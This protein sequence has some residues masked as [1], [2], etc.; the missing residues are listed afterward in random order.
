MKIFHSKKG[1]IAYTSQGEGPTS[2][3]L[4]HNS[5]GNH[6]MM[7]YT[8]S[9]FSKK[10][11][12]IV[13]DLLGHAAS[14]SPKIEYSLTL[15]AESMIQLCAHENLSQVV[16]IG[17][18]YGADIGIEIAKTSP[19]L[20]SHLILIEPPIFM[21]PWILEV[22]EQQIKNLEN[23]HDEWAQ[24]T[25]DFVMM[26]ASDYERK[27]A[28]KALKETPAFVKAS[29]YKHLLNWDKEH[30]FSCSIPT[31]LI[32]AS[33]P[34]CKEKKARTVFSNLQVGRVVCSGPWVNL[35]VPLQVHAMMDRFLEIY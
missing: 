12:V 35:E 33:Q 31:L 9:H 17:L 5:G 19:A 3:L 11:R 7:H 13:P 24:E 20:V 34:F 6:E 10:G 32:Q 8:S 18:N 23:P 29:I 15:F 1:K 2:F 14:D 22:V 21:E 25:V 30:S 27:I 4:V 26:K 28:L 16:F